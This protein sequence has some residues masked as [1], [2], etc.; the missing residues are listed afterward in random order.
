VSLS[1]VRSSVRDTI[2]AIASASGPAERI[3][4][5]ISGPD[6]RS[7]LQRLTGSLPDAPGPSRSTA[8]L[9]I[10]WPELV[11]AILY[12]WPGTRSYTGQPSAEI[13]IPGSVPL[14]EKTLEAVLSCGARA[15]QAGEFTLRAFL[16]GRIDLTQAEAVLGVIDASNDR[17]LS[18]ALKQLAGGLAGQI[19]QLRGE[20]LNLLADL[21]AGL[22]FVDEDIEF[23]PQHVLMTRIQQAGQEVRELLKQS[24]D[25]M[26][27]T[28]RP[29]V[30][31]AGLPNAGKS[32]LF[33]ALSGRSSAI[34]TEI[35][36]TTRDYLCCPV[37]WNGLETDLI[38]TAGWEDTRPDL[39]PLSRSSSQIPA[40]AQ[41]ARRNQY[42]EADLIV[43]C[44]AAD[45]SL[46][47]QQLDQR[48]QAEASQHRPILLCR[49]R[50]DLQPDDKHDGPAPELL[51]ISAVTGFGL[52]A[53]RQKV[54]EL[55]SQQRG[56]RQ[57]IG[58]T[59]ARC[60][61]SLL[62]AVESLDR[63]LDTAQRQLG[64]ELISVELR[65]AL[66]SLGEVIGASCTDDILDRV[67]S[68]FCI[69]K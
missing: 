47:D 45:L 9:Q 53:L 4:I 39:D 31:L 7:V 38:D 5:R 13:A 24:A 32:T 34:V 11:P 1:G 64:D 35:P 69:G 61:D 27:S 68:R 25:R 50:S 56:G 63:A 12:F 10:G 14:A 3:I 42:A 44:S 67:F 60:R 6:V 16:A 28:G 19:Q 66:D 33:N 40:A 23:V 49:T 37:N 58:S 18:A 2:A 15:A 26:Q 8:N 62:R 54:A 21:E 43:W 30:V 57:F 55:L 59:A 46:D 65:D 36:G 51:R 22:D 17:E 41:Q 20:L 48:L 52:P 29:R